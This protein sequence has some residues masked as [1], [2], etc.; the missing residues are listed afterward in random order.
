MMSLASE[1]ESMDEND[2][3]QAAK[4][5]RKMSDMTGLELGEGMQEAIRRMEAGEDPDA[6]EKEMGDL[7]EQEDPFLMKKKK[8]GSV[9]ARSR[10]APFR[11]ETL[12]EM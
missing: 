1:A 2:P 4:L 6:I 12:Y 11:D 5:M 8:G 3:R 10:L 7:L 9:G